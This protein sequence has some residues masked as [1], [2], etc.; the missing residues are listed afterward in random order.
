MDTTTLTPVTSKQFPDGA[1]PLPRGYVAGID[2]Q[3]VLFAWPK[4]VPHR[5]YALCIAEVDFEWQLV[6]KNFPTIP[7]REFMIAQGLRMEI[8]FPGMRMTAKAPKMTTILRKEYGMKGTP[9]NL[10]EQFLA[11]RKISL[12]KLGTERA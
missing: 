1:P 10:L 9:A 11:F 2:H 5:V 3:G 4:S 12:N 8:K 6:D 7:I